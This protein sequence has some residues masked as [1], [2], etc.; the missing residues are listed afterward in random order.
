[1]EKKLKT[2]YAPNMFFGECGNFNLPTELGWLGTEI[3]SESVLA[4]IAF[5]NNLDRD[6]YETSETLNTKYWEFIEAKY[7]GINPDGLEEP[8]EIIFLQFYEAEDYTPLCMELF[9]A[10]DTIMLQASGDDEFYDYAPGNV[11][12][13]CCFLRQL[14]KE[15]F[16]NDLQKMLEDRGHND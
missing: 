6:K 5:I 7:P 4:Y 11:D 15:N 8:T 1:M 13:I 14:G 2:I 16:A 10:A 9:N 12:C 3:D